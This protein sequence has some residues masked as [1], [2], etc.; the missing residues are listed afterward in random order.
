MKRRL[1]LTEKTTIRFNIIILGN[2]FIGKILS[3]YPNI[4]QKN[5]LNTCF[6][7]VE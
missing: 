7:D 6:S 4:F 3:N 1:P 5:Y 2:L